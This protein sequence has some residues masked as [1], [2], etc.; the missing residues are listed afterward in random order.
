MTAI[1][2]HHQSNEA[3][4]RLT[5]TAQGEPGSGNAYHLYSIEGFDTTSNPDDP[6]LARYGAPGLHTTVLFQNGP[7][8]EVGVNGITHEAL[9]AILIHRLE[10]FQAGLY[11]SEDNEMALNHLKDALH[12]LNLRT[13]KRVARGVEGT[14]TV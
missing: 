2:T 8:K 12:C 4:S 14:H 5:I 13:Q 3:N 7:I 9:L 1:L 11:K 10:G 6:F